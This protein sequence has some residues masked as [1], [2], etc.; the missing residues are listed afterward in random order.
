MRMATTTRVDDR[1]DDFLAPGHPV[2][3]ARRYH[4]RTYAA[5]EEERL[6][7]KVWLM[8]CRL[9]EVEKVGDFV[10]F[11]IAHESIIV[12]RTAPDTIKAYY[13][14]CQ[15]RGRR[16]KDQPCG[17]T[18]KFIFCPFHGWRWTIDGKLDRVINR[19]DWDNHPGYFDDKN[20]AGVKVDSWAGWVFVSMDPDIEPLLD[21]LGP[22]PGFIDPYRLDECRIHWYKTIRFPC[23]W[24]TVI[25]AFNENYHVETTHSQL[26][27]FGLSK[28]PAFVR[29]KHAHFRVEVSAGST[30]GQNLGSARNFK[31]LIESIE[32]RETERYDWLLALSTPYSVT[33]A[34]RL[35]SE[36][37]ADADP[38]AI[39]GKF[40]QLHRE[41]MEKAGAKWP[42]SI[43]GDVVA[44]A[45]IDWHLFPNFI[46]LPSIDGALVYRARPD[47]NDPEHCWYDVWWL[48]R[49][50]PD[51]QPDWKH[52]TFHSLEEAR[53]VNRFLEQDFSNLKA[54]QKGIH[55][56]GFK[57][58]AYNPVQ[59]VE[60]IHFER[61]LD[62]YIG[63]DAAR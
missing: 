15:H 37:S 19:E 12:V 57:G 5:A 20:L 7:P 26:N 59:E 38:A 28:S 18:G 33:A 55:S 17:N 3:D 47:A 13:N 6:W 61:M 22:V 27:K 30:S 52:E 50:G 44:A 35:R 39:V 40:R 42:E 29:G 34:K 36:I 62:E 2:S 25:N 45:G 32:I 63:A 58:S 9:E 46:F 8:A 10:V 4:S 11:D 24:K 51:N 56:R 21:F 53:G 43:N 48:S 1:P 16:L 31:D 14:V 49:F 60:V 54:V 41:E 23:N